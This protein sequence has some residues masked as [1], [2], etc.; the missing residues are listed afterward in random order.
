VAASVMRNFGIV[1]ET[2]IEPVAS[3]DSLLENSVGVPMKAPESLPALH[4][5]ED[6]FL[7]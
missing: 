6:L 4:G 2:E 7:A 5:E 1:F 3:L